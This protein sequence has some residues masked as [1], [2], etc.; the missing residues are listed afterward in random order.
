VAGG[1]V[2]NREGKVMTTKAAKLRENQDRMEMDPTIRP[3]L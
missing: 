1:D 3:A 2:L